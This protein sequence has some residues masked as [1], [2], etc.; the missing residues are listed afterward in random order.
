MITA[1]SDKTGDPSRPPAALSSPGLRGRKRAAVVPAMMIALS[2]GAV[3]L[4]VRCADP[5]LEARALR[6]LE[7]SGGKHVHIHGRPE[8]GEETG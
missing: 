8:R 4:W 5:D 7:E 1:A 3:L 6:I 2:A